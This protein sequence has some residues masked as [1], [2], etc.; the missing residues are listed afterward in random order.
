MKENRNLKS[1]NGTRSYPE[2]F[3]SILP[4]YCISWAKNIFQYLQYEAHYLSPASVLSPRIHVGNTHVSF[5]DFHRILNTSVCK[6]LLF[7]DHGKSEKPLLSELSA[8]AFLLYVVRKSRIQV[9]E[10]GFI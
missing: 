6:Y 7:T 2:E 10:E 1:V 4:S 3:V 9:V 5:N 8:Y